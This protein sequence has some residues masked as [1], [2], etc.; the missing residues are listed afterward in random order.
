M[1]SRP[2]CQVCG[3]QNHPDYYQCDKCGHIAGGTC[4]GLICKNSKCLGGI[5]KKI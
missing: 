1:P 4:A 3:S 2:M 5:Y